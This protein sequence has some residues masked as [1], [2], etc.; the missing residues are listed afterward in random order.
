MK[1]QPVKTTYV[2]IE[3]LATII[4]AETAP[5]KVTV[6]LNTV[7]AMRKTN[8]PFVGLVSKLT[9]YQVMIN[10]NYENSVNNQLKRENANP[11]KFT[12]GE[13]PWGEHETKAI[14]S[15]GDI[16]YLQLKHEKTL[17]ESFVNLADSSFIDKAELV[18]FLQV[19]NNSN[20]GLEKPVRVISPK[21]SN[22]V[23]IAMNGE[24]FK[25][26]K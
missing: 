3:E 11:A 16:L 24:R 15:K 9:K 7:P 4:A 26:K 12:A 13:R 10:F 8:N 19:S 20:Q 17:H 2:T 18:P 6:V 25:V 5:R 23:E 21:F 14:I 1:R 22:I